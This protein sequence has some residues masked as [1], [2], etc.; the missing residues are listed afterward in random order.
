MATAA[1]DKDTSTSTKK[2][3]SDNQQEQE[4]TTGVVT[5]DNTLYLEFIGDGRFSYPP[6]AN[7]HWFGDSRAQA[8]ELLAT[9]LWTE[10]DKAGY[11]KL[12]SQG[13]A[14]L[15]NAQN[16]TL[17]QAQAQVEQVMADP[18]ATPEQ[19]AHVQMQ[20]QIQANIEASSNLVGPSQSPAQAEAEQAQVEAVQSEVVPTTDPAV[21]S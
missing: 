1:E 7:T 13:A 20:A 21:Q 6:V 15:A 4:D 14:A 8:D 3:K 18:T 19:L 2:K 9:G 5:G 11:F 12:M 16:P 17:E 10:T